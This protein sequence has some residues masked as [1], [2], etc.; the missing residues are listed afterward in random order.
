MGFLEPDGHI[1]Q[2]VTMLSHMA[3]YQ[4]CGLNPW[5]HHLANVLLHALNAG[6]VFAWLQLMTGRDVAESVGGGVVCR[7]P[8]A[9]RSGRLGDGTPGC[10]QRLLR[11]CSR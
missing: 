2:P 9:R 11:S 1:W 10:A 3:I 5:G 7:S 8:T 4:V 6:L